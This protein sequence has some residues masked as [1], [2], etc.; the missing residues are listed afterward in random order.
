MTDPG[1]V[2]HV[3]REYAG[4]A[5][6][7]G[8]KDVV[9]GLAEAS[10]R[11]GIATSVV[12]PRYGFLPAERLRGR[13][14]A[15]FSVSL[16]D[17]DRG[18]QF[19]EEPVRVHSFS[20]AG[21]RILLVD[22]SRFAS[23]RSVYTYTDADQA[24]NQWQK[25][26]TGHWDAHQ[27]NL[28]LQR[29]TLETALALGE[30][31]E[32]IHCHDGHAAFLPALAREVIRYRERLADT[33]FVVTIHNAGRG[34]HQEIWDPQFASLLTGLDAAVIAKGLLA[35][36]IDPLLLAGFYASLVTVSEQ[37][38]QE[39]LAEKGDELSGGLGRA[40]RERGIP[41]RG[42]TNGVDPSPW[43]PRTAAAGLPKGFDPSTGD[44]AGKRECRRVLSAKTGL[45][46]AHRD[47]PL[48]AFVGRL[49]AQ[50]G[51]DI[52]V[53][54]LRGLLTR[55][56]PLQCVVLGQGEAG[57]ESALAALARANAGTLAFIPRYDAPLSSLIYAASDFLL[58]PSA[59]EPCGLTDF[60]AQIS[61]SIPIVHRVG[62]L[63]KVRDGE[64]GLSYD[65]Q[66]PR[67]LAEQ[68]LRACSLF[69]DD[70]ER[71][72]GMRARAFTEIFSLH[73]WDR[74]LAAGY[75]PEYRAVTGGRWTPR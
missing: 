32:V 33:G 35:G 70:P 66:T 44:L 20:E 45:A 58:V 60:I 37:Y 26:G 47:W 61:G 62:G 30:R 29:S 57:Y 9:R 71:L 23:K 31:P 67:A 8:V 38:A 43:D 2:W 10:A 51:I 69:R 11:A 64:T 46:A 1:S 17:H 27:L 25:R 42:I 73:T 4:I 48:F 3:A 6:A 7:G 53:E 63:A 56:A 24:A 18:N 34:Y 16:P 14:V 68:I 72:A 54:T 36:T 13:P 28:L 21:V 55:E 52:L 41:L 15:E 74:V 65:E 39:L 5:E 22:S 75:L 40:L 12:L 50:K 49:T 59:Y 19:F